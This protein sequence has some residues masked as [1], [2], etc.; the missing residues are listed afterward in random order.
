MIRRI[1]AVVL[2]AV[3]AVGPLAA[4][5]DRSDCDTDASAVTQVMAKPGGGGKGSSRGKAGTTGKKPK[6][7]GNH[8]T[9]VVHDGD[10]DGDD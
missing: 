6:P 10:C 7:A 4:C 2:A 5:G 8:G 3:M 9:T 1:P